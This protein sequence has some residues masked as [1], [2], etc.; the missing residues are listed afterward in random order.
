MSRFI[1]VDRDTAY[2]LPP[3][4]NEWLPANHLARFV[5][6]VIEQLDLSALTRQYG[7]RGSAAH[8]PARTLHDRRKASAA[9]HE[10]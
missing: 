9:V 1:S 5:V 3:L 10:N 4:V 7:G 6:E 2:L 8:H